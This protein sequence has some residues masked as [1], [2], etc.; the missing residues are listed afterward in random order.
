[1]SEAISFLVSNAVLFGAIAALVAILGASLT[2][3][4]PIWRSMSGRPPRRIRI[5]AVGLKDKQAYVA[6]HRGDWAG[7]HSDYLLHEIFRKKTFNGITDMQK[8]ISKHV[9]EA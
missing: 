1:M 7:D 8:T 9:E 2:I 5:S 6:H 4:K 3:G